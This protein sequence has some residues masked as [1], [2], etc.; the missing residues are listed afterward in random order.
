MTE[1]RPAPRNEGFRRDVVK[2]A[3]EATIWVANIPRMITEEQ[4]REHFKGYGE[5]VKVDI[6]ENREGRMPYVYVHFH[7][8]EEAAEAIQK[9][10]GTKLDKWTIVVRKGYETKKDND[11]ERSKERPR[12]RPRDHDK[13]KDRRRDIGYPEDSYP[14][15]YPEDY[16]YVDKYPDDHIYMDRY[17]E[18]R[19]S[20]YPRYDPYHDEVAH[21]RRY[22]RYEPR[23]RDREFDR[24]DS[25]YRDRYYR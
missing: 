24:H 12:E 4:V 20:G 18:D 7:T 3:Q 17:P 14:P 19:H 25:R 15:R 8:P 23:S 22:D 6:P 13:E 10:N 21:D 9:G 1:Q 11:R 16:R 5:I 2:T